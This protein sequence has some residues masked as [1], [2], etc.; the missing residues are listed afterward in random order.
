M[1][2]VENVKICFITEKDKCKKLVLLKQVYKT[3]CGKRHSKDTPERD[4]QASAQ[5]SSMCDTDT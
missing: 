5:H 1:E 2:V 4:V 3:M